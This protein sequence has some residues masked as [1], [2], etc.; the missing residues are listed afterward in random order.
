[1][2]G[3]SNEDRKGRRRVLSGASGLAATRQDDVDVETAEFCSRPGQDIVLSI[4]ITVL[5]DYVRAGCP[6]SLGESMLEDVARHSAR[7]SEP[8][9][10]EDADPRSFSRQLRV[11]SSRAEPCGH[12]DEARTTGETHGN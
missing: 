1:V 7:A 12:R 9:G 10:T 5:E 2:A 11:R 3:G 4:R 8:V 6:A